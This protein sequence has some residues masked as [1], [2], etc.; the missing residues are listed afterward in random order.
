[1]PTTTIDDRVKSLERITG[2]LSRRA[3]KYARAYITPFPISHGVKGEDIR[4]EILR[5]MFPCRGIIKTVVTRF[6][7]RPKDGTEVT[8][9]VSGVGGSYSRSFDSSKQ[10]EII[11]AQL[12]VL[13]G[14][15][16]TVSLDGSKEITEFWIAFLWIPTV[17][18]VEVK[19]FLY[20]EIEH[21]LLQE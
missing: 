10:M 11:D 18:D 8:F 17:S 13:A 12:D 4:G 9:S 3:R 14:D 7:E 19:S 5:Y 20:D 16:L 21:D 6:N 15:K 1:M 2:R